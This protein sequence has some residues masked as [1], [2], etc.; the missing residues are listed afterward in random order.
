[1]FGSLNSKKSNTLQPLIEGPGR[2][3][4]DPKIFTLVLPPLYDLFKRGLLLEVLR[5]VI[6]TKMLKNQLKNFALP[7]NLHKSTFID[8]KIDSNSRFQQPK[9]TRS[10][11]Y[12]RVW[13]RKWNGSEKLALIST[14]DRHSVFAQKQWVV[15]GIFRCGER[16]V[17][18]LG[19]W[20]RMYGVKF[21]KW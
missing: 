9:K 13:S 6:W 8:T 19:N 15:C 4:F 11:A 7:P 3:F 20:K 2:L 12:N 14:G 10:R 21:G 18:D 1:M 5:Y 16:M 17:F